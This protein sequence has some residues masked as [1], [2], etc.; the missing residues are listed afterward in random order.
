MKEKKREKKVMLIGK[1][2]INI[3]LFADCMI[4]YLENPKV[5][6][7]KFLKL[8][9]EFSK[10]ID[11]KVNTQTSSYFYILANNI[12]NWNKKHNTIYNSSKKS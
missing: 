8:L 1:E 7:K 6:T 3:S 2:E 12:G 11:D 4:V 9:R 5:S 10:I